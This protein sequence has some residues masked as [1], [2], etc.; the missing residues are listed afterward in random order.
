MKTKK[1]FGPERFQKFVQKDIDLEEFAIEMAKTR[2]WTENG[3]RE[4]PGQLKADVN[5]EDSIDPLCVKCKN[6]PADPPKEDLVLYLHC[7]KYSGPDWSFE[8]KMPHWAAD[9]YQVPKFYD[10][11]LK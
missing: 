11:Y 10:R 9:G 1:V 8:S 2:G 5:E 3:F 6:R 7:F 4:E